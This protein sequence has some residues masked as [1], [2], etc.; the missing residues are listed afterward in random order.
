MLLRKADWAERRLRNSCHKN[1]A[2]VA[3]AVIS[4]AM[5]TSREK[6]VAMG[7]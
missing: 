3:V 2:L 4:T 5:P 7:R 1:P 6:R